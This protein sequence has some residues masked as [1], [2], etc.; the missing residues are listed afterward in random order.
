LP[1]VL[2]LVIVYRHWVGSQPGNTVWWWFCICIGWCSEQNF[3]VR[4]WPIDTC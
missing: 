2:N 3:Q 1:Y 4:I